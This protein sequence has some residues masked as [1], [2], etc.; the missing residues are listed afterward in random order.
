MLGGSGGGKAQ[1]GYL[2]DPGLLGDPQKRSGGGACQGVE[3]R[4][5]RS[6]AWLTPGPEL[7][8]QLRLQV[9]ESRPVCWRTAAV[10]FRARRWL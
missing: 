10:F 5:A 7:L 3:I 4:P 1:T 9:G 8:E 2:R 6:S